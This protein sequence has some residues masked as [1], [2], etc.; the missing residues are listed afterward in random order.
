MSAELLAAVTKLV[1]L[2]NAQA[3]SGLITREIIVQVGRVQQL[4]ARERRGRT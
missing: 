1:E 4:L 3:A 2:L